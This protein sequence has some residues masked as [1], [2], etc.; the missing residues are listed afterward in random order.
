MSADLDILRAYAAGEL[1]APDARRR[2]GDCSFAELLIALAANDLPL[3]R[4]PVA[5][6]EA[7]VERARRWLF[8]PDDVAA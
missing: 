5:G 4:A 6:R 8:H 1:S 2:L 7:S 3:P